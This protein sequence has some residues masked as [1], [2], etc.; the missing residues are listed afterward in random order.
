MQDFEEEG[1]WCDEKLAVCSASITAKDLRAL[2]SL[3]QKHK[4][5][6]DEMVRRHNRFLSG[7]LATGQD[8]I[9]SGHPLA[10]QLQDRV[11]LVQGKWA[12][13]KEEATKR[14]VTLESAT[15]AYLFFSDC[16][17]TD[18]IIKESIT[19]AKSKV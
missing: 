8:M 13:L 12:M 18:S 17:E 1:Q 9:R 4:A 6:E 14:R 5:L 11:R 15:D 16:N 2:T 3:Q 7:P 10:E 19:L